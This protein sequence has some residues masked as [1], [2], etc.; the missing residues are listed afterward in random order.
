M[1]WDLEPLVN[2]VVSNNVTNQQFL[3]SGANGAP[4]TTLPPGLTESNNK[5]QVNPLLT[6]PA[7]YDFHLLAGSPAIDAGFATSDVTHDIERRTR[8][9][10]SAHDA[11]AYERPGGGD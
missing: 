10:G 2:V 3:I 11:G 9:Q 1:A 5:W 7:S 4:I 6:D 8:P